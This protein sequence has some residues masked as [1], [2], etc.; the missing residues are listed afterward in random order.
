MATF[1][2]EI[3]L[4]RLPFK[5]P[6]F[7]PRISWVSAPA[8]EVWEP[9]IA[10]I[11]AAWLQTERDL[12]AAGVRP[13]ALQNVNPDNLP[14][15][16]AEEAKRGLIILPLGKAARADGYQSG[17]QPI[18]GAW[19]YRC[20]ITTAAHA[21]AWARAWQDGDNAAI[22]ALLGYPSCCCKFFERVWVS[23]KWFDTTVPMALPPAPH[24]PDARSAHAAAGQTAPSPRS[25]GAQRPNEARGQG[26]EVRGINMLW[27]WFG[28]RPVSFLP[29]SFDCH[30]ARKQA[31]VNVY[32]MSKAFPEESAW[33]AEILRWPAKYTSFRGIAEITTPIFRASVPTD[34][35]AERFELRYVGA[36]YPAEGAKGS[37]FPFRRDV[38]PPVT[39]QIARPSAQN[40]AVNGFS[41]PSAMHAAHNRLLEAVG[42]GPYETVL[43]LGCGDGTLLSRIPA[44]RRVGIESDAIAWSEAN[45][46]IERAIRGDCTRQPFVDAVI[47]AEKPDLIIAQR[48]RNPPETLAGYKV[49]SYSYENEAEPPQLT[50]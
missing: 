24:S 4:T 39:I 23:E 22:G 10:R 19:D 47:Q 25:E 31:L 7:A 12:V 18:T 26:T 33:I 20:S 41:S 28:V 16:L 6:E 2:T 27:R 45:K 8:R 15:L 32:Q 36:G 43:D 48:H 1:H 3:T 34:A 44:K 37:G 14:A 49:L 42:P 9:R 50:G 46:R 21:A 13:S 30:D 40:P 5:L 29:C 11:S 17:S 35:L 38:T